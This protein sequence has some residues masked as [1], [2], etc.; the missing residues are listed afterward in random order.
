MLSGA[1]QGSTLGPLLFLVHV[2][3]LPNCLECTTPGMYTD[4]TQI[5][6]T[7]ETVLELQNL[8]DRDIE[9]LI[10]Y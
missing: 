3:D 1:P 9:N 10:H 8:L 6:A 2:N 7:A 5:T 4:D